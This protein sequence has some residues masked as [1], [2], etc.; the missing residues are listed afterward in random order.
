MRLTPKKHH[1]TA[2]EVLAHGALLP[3]AGRVSA[4]LAGGDGNQWHIAVQCTGLRQR[5]ILA[6]K[7]GTSFRWIVCISCTFESLGHKRVH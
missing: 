1:P 6:L 2:P 5:V 7:Q 3:V 4:G